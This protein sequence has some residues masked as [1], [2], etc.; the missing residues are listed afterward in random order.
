MS[1]AGSGEEIEAGEINKEVFVWGQGNV[2]GKDVGG[3][4]FLSRFVGCG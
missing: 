4:V 2:H 1:F 3:F